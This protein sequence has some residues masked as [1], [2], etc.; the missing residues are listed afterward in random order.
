MRVFITGIAGFLGSHIADKLIEQGNEVSGC[1]NLIGGYLENIPSKADF[2]QVDAIYLNQ[3]K[4]MTKDSDV[5]IHT[6]CTAYE[7]LSVFSPYLIGQNTYQIS[8]SV[9]TAAAE[10]NVSKVINCSSMARYGE[11][12]V[13]PF[14][15]DLIPKPQDPYGIAKLASE[16]T[17]EIL[18]KVHNFEYVNLVPHNII[19]PRQKYDDPYRNVVSIMINRILN[20]KPP[21]IYGDGS[22]ERCFSDI[23]DVVDPIIKSL[24]TQEAIGQTIN[25]GPD[26]DVITI[27]ELAYKVLNVLNSDLEPI[28]VNPR[29]QEV[30]LA[31]CSADKARELLGYNTSVSLDNSIEKIA[32]WIIEVGPKDFRYHL[33]IEIVNEKTPETWTKKL[34]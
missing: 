1:D 17:L 23:N 30:K 33:D 21:I 25:I 12:E 27:K 5:I 34:F 29:P 15:E 31:H 18:S 28:Y 7:G 19:G 2:H 20:G 6:A 8:M 24:N 26:E 9:F 22:Q 3:M 10:N 13:I 4:K 11:Q 16:Q 32:N 14:T